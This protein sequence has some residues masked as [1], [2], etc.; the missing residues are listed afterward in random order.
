MTRIESIAFSPDAKTLAIA[1]IRR[2]QGRLLGQIDRR[3]N[4]GDPE[5]DPAPG[6]RAECGLFTRWEDARDRRAGD[7]KAPIGPFVR[8][9]QLWDIATERMVR[10]IRQELSVNDIM[11]SGQ[12]DGL[13][14]L[15]FS[16]DG[17]LLAAADVDFRV[18]LIDVRTGG[19]QQTLQGHTEVVLGLAFSPDGRARNRRV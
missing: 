6:D 12:L 17:T 9:V 5:D 13:R 15:R 3:G 4:G 1:A 8:T 2:G 16:P 7:P 18:R 19:V 11:K 14:D 10:E